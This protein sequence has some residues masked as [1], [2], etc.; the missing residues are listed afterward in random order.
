MG[1]KKV[2]SA[3][4]ATAYVLLTIGAVV[5]VNLI[6]TRVFGRLDLTENHVYTLA[7]GSKEIVAQPA[8]LPDGQGVHLERSCR[9]SCSRV[10]RY[11]RDLLDEYRTYSKGK[12]RFEA[13]R[14]RRPTRRS[15]KR[16]AP[17]QGAEAAGAGDAR[18]G[19]R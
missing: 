3:S 6:G 15:R 4:N 17:V 1:R 19:S 2:M 16:P 12:L 9:P 10:S 11:V 5:L 8:R 7:P 13:L 18:A 14:P